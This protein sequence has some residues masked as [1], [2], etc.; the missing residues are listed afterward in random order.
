MKRL[1]FSASCCLILTLLLCES[2]A[3]QTPLAIGEWE[4][5][6]SYQKG[7]YVTESANSIIYTTGTS[8]YYLD[9][10]DLSISLLTR[11]DGLA[12]TEIELLRF[13]EPTG[14]LII[15]YANSVIDLFREGRFSTLRQIDNF[16]FSGGDNR[17]NDIFF[18]P[19]NL[20]YLAAGYGISALNLNDETFTFTTFSGVGIESIALYENTLYA[21]T[22]EGI[23]RVSKDG[24]N[25]NDFGSWE[26]L[27]P[28]QG[29]LADYSTFALNV[30]RDEL[31]F[32]V[33]E[34][35][36]RWNDSNPVVFYDSNPDNYRI[37]YLSAGPDNLI[38]GY[39]PTGGEARKVVILSNTGVRRILVLNCLTNPRNALQD[40]DGRIWFGDDGFGIRYLTGTDAGNC[41]ILRYP[42]PPRNFSYR[43]EHDGEALWVAAGTLGPNLTT[44]FN[45]QG[46]YRYRDGIWSVFNRDNK[47]A[48]AGRDEVINSFDD[49]LD[50]VGVAI[51]PVSNLIWAGSYFEGAFSLNRETEEATLYD[52]LNSP[53]QFAVGEAPGRV[54][55][56]N[57][58]VDENG[59]VYF[60]NP[61]AEAG[62]PLSVRTPEGEWAALG[63]NC[64]RNEA[65]TV[66]IDQA[67]LVWALHG[68]NAGG[69]I[70]VTDTK[71]TLLDPSD[72]ECRTILTS[73]SNLINNEVRSIA[74]DLDGEVWIGTS[75]GVMV[76]NCGGA[77]LDPDIC[78]GT[79]IAVFD[80]FEN[81]GLLLETEDCQAITID[82]ANRKWVATTGGVY[83]LSADGREQLAFFDEDNS[84]LL[85]NLV[86]DVA[87]N[88]NDG[89]V[90]FG[91]ENGIISYRSDAT[92]AGRTN[93]ETLK[94]FPNPV[95]PGYNGPIAI[96]GF[97]RNAR[98]KITDL[99]GKLVFETNAQGGQ[100]VWNGMDYNGRRVQTGVY[101]VF[102]STNGTL[103]NAPTSPDAAV[104][105][106]VFIH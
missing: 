7:E 73:N 77:V 44:T 19:D 27:G 91:T 15:I 104:G 50:I 80:E 102:A 17:I 98:I 52:E 78:R 22:Q 35:V 70:T 76:F 24:A 66:A 68:I 31:Y 11:D 4:T 79:T 86:R 61:L 75:T 34:D 8:I 48:V 65:F 93:R 64:G 92:E 53:L 105:K 47:P 87:I 67:G 28:G 30:W 89:T 54:R 72:D 81:G 96:E 29:L 84:P 45:A 55:V 94:V 90:Y 100:V 13:H 1:L 95:E 43:M 41:E 103:R 9:K 25:V 33:N 36:W 49:L 23:Y 63:E 46:L 3:A 85:D 88:P 62:R 56:G 18:G 26:L 51:D 32:G 82:G 14:T 16:N 39:R 106:I 20:I 99:S 101:L 5:L 12:E 97:S 57:I 58:A 37:E 42:G 6:Q 21:G 10:A 74:I 60:S 71:G 83:L 69:G 40:A 59:N 2:L 38:A